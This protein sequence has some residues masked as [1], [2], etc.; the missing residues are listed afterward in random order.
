MSF[1]PHHLYFDDLEIGQEWESGGRTVTEADIVNYAGFSGD[2]NPMHMDREY[3]RNTPFRQPIAHGLG[4]FS[5]ASGLGVSSPLVRTIALFAVREW[6][7]MNPVYPG[8]TIRVRTA[9]VEKKL[10]GR[11]K[12]GE[13]VWK[14]TILNQDGKV[15]QQGEVITL[16]E[17]RPLAPVSSGSSAADSTD[18]LG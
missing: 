11:G 6:K 4:V 17:C 1:G 18:E 13:V 9:V 12:R 7:F 14:R 3:A 2:F 15:I 5:M 10:R 16:V 8:D